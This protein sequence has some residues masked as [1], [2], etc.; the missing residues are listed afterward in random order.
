MLW[1]PQAVFKWFDDS[2]FASCL[3]FIFT[4]VSSGKAGLWEGGACLIKW[5]LNVWILNQATLNAHKRLSR[6]LN[7]PKHLWKWNIPFRSESL[8]TLTDHMLKV[9]NSEIRFSL[10]VP[11]TYLHVAYLIQC[12]KVSSAPTYCRKA[13]SFYVRRDMVQTVE[14]PGLRSLS[15]LDV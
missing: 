4:A 14:S 11:S 10:Q 13:P 12:S 1:A 3:I 5:I 15:L 8:S 6:R 9:W 7:D 2:V